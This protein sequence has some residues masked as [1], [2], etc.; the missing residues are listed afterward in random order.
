MGM[1]RVL[2]GVSGWDL[3]VNLA[4]MFEG[5]KRLSFLVGKIGKLILG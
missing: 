4:G 1:G 3:L 2:E 5:K